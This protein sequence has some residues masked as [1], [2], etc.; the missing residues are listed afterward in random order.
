M[1]AESKPP[2]ERLDAEVER[3]IREIAREE[4]SAQS[5]WYSDLLASEAKWLGGSS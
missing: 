4:L 3:R 2:A 5:Q 1:T